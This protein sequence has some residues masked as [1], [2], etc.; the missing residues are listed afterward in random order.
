M[1]TAGGHYVSRT[2]KLLKSFDKTA[3]LVRDSVVERYGSDLAEAIRKEAR[4]EFEK[5]IPDIP[6]IKGP[7]ALNL[8]LRITAM[9]ISVYKAMKKLGKTPPEAW[10]ICHEALTLRTERIPKILRLLMKYYLF[11]GFVKNRARKVAGKS[12][13]EPFGDF[14]FKYVEGDG[15]E[16]DWGVDYTGCANYEFVKRQEAKDFAPYV[17]LSDIALSRA[18]GWG[19]I[20]TETLADGC[21]RCDFRFKKGG[22]TRISSTIP[23][24]QAT[25]ERMT[26]KEAE[27]H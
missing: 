11:T 1:G 8:F 24:V 9:E 14:A 25:I 6:Y 20:R 12:Q 18:M 21:D 10:E 19:L 2:Q 7:P 16:F 13:K 5:L 4:D 27:R 17:C 15:K 3:S 22:K 23:E 26:K